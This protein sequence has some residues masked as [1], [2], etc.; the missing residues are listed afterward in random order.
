MTNE[1]KMKKE[2]TNEIKE[3]VDTL[4][5]EVNTKECA[6]IFGMSQAIIKHNRFIDYITGNPDIYVEITRNEA[7]EIIDL[8][9]Y[10][11]FKEIV[12]RR[13]RWN[14][15]NLKDEN[16]FP[17]FYGFAVNTKANKSRYIPPTN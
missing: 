14:M 3:I 15:R 8:A 16:S 17:I 10:I 4:I 12:E 9:S 6:T 2:M 13:V 1:I 11:N 7:G 5:T